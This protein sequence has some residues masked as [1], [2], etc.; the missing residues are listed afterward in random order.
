MSLL[1]EA[2]SNSEPP[3]DG[4]A[5]FGFRRTSGLTIASIIATTTCRTIAS[6][7]KRSPESGPNRSVADDRIRPDA[8]ARVQA[9][10]FPAREDWLASHLTRC[11]ACAFTR[12]RKPAAR[13]RARRK[14]KHRSARADGRD[15]GRGCAEAGRVARQAARCLTV[16][17]VP[18]EDGRGRRSFFELRCEDGFR[19]DGAADHG[20]AA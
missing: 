5:A 8:S 9:S 19:A 3:A 7:T 14:R 20:C 12:I 2:S 1:L 16:G 15:A 11:V 10:G 13:P 4:M 17:M 18:R 6:A